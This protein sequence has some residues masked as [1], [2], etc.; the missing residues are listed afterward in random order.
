ACPRS[1]ESR[2]QEYQYHEHLRR[3]HRTIRRSLH[4]AAPGYLWFDADHFLNTMAMIGVSV[5]SSWVLLPVS[6]RWRPEPT[7][8]ARAGRVLGWFW[9][10][11][12]P[13]TTWWDFHVR[14]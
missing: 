3:K 1:A 9:I 13:L 10:A 6:G 4:G 7:W 8:I 14:F 12:L 2:A 11:I 5:G